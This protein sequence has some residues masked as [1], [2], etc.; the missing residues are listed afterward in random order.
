VYVDES[1]YNLCI[2]QSVY[3]L[4]IWIYLYLFENYVYYTCL[5]IMYIWICIMK[6]VC[7]L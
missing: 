6:T 5:K 1:V 7:D 3:N 4:Y 2:M